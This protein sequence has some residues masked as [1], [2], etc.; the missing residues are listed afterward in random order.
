MATEVPATSP[1]LDDETLFRSVR[2]EPQHFGCDATG[3]L[4]RLS[5]SAFNDRDMQP[6]VDRATLRAGGAG[7]SRKSDSDGVVALV[8]VEV[9]AIKGVAT[10]DSK[11]RAKQPHQVDVVHAPEA[12]NHSHSLVKT[13]PQVASDGAFK[14]LKEALCFIAA[15]KGWAFPPRSVRG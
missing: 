11:G 13:A 3:E 7:D 14:R 8:A 15:T 2:D 6:S 10:R 4:K 12:D 1:V 9:R 5:H